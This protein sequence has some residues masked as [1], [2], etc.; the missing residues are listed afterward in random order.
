MRQQC[1]NPSSA[2]KA[3]RELANIV[4]SEMKKSGRVK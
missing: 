2:E 3:I 4:V 1:F